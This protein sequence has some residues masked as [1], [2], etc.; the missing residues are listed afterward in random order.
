MSQA[1]WDAEHERQKEEADGAAGSC[2]PRAEGHGGE[3]KASGRPTS[4]SCRPCR[5]RTQL[6]GRVAQLWLKK[7]RKALNE[8]E[9]RRVVGGSLMPEG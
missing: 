8:D 4:A 1:A 3:A 7:N 9:V 5:R 6:P 2:S